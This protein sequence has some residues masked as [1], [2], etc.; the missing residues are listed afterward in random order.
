MRLEVL[1]IQ[2]STLLLFT[3][4]YLFFLTGLDWIN[5]PDADWYRP[6]LVAF[7]VI[8]ITAVLQQY[9]NNDDF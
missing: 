9:A 2:R 7:G 8:I 4:I 6:F 5:A 1:Y 3:F